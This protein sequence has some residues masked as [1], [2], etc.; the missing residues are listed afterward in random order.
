MAN[1]VP[2]K[3]PSCGG[4]LTLDPSTDAAVCPFCNNAFIVEKAI[5]NYNTVTHVH[6]AEDNKY[7]VQKAKIEARSNDEEG[8]KHIRLMVS[9]LLMV[10]IYAVIILMMRLAI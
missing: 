6:E 4:T 5:T 1:L 3:C 8:K 10:V 7:T 2:A 9:M